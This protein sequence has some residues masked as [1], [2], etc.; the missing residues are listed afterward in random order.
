MWL[1]IGHL[2]FLL[3]ELLGSHSLSIFIFLSLPFKIKKFLDYKYLM[4]CLLYCVYLLVFYLVSLLSSLLQTNVGI[5]FFVDTIY[6]SIQISIYLL[7]HWVFV[8][9]RGLFSSCGERGLL[10]VAVHRLLIALA[11]L[12]VEHG[13]QAHGLPQL[14]HAG[15]V[16]VACS[17][18]SAGSVVVAH[19]LSCSAACGIC[20]DQGSNPCR[21]NWQ[22]DS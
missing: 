4:P 5:F 22:A 8:A 19:G 1:F 3:R 11:S 2:Y 10:L 17:L 18:Q 14:W 7:R 9:A 13:L 20:L 21:L 6:L 16:V 15:S 12:V